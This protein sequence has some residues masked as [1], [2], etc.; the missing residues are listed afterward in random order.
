MTYFGCIIILRFQVISI[1]VI[2]LIIII[3]IMLIAIIILWSTASWS[4]WLVICISMMLGYLI[5]SL[6]WLRSYA[7][8]SFPA[9]TSTTSYIIAHT[10][11]SP[12]RIWK[13]NSFIALKKL[14][15][16]NILLILILII[17]SLLRHK[18]MLARCKRRWFIEQII[19]FLLSPLLIWTIVSATITIILIL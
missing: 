8:Q 19:R 16:I 2:I 9:I 1:I 5:K 10:S 7:S 4:V 17:N 15:F 6:Q 3:I 11:L 12:D 14:V 13:Y 18:Q